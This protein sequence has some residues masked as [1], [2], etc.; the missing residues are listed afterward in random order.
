[1]S[2]LST[3]PSAAGLPSGNGRYIAVAL[4]LLLLIGGVIYW[5]KTQKPDVVV[6]TVDAGVYVPHSRNIEDD[7]PLPPAIEDAGPDTATKLVG[8]QSYGCEVKKCGGA[9]A[10]DLEHMLAFRAKGAHR[11]YDQALAVDSTLTGNVSITL[12][13]GT[14]GIPCSVA[15]ASNTTG[16]PSVGQCMAAAMRGG[17]Y[18][19]PKGGCVDVTVP[20]LLKNK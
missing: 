12:R 9:P 4:L 1:M 5:K 13:I 14:N 3:P 2:S 19:A 11:C 20:I 18:P 7:I 8:P 17:G 10:G 15:V 6:T 16:N